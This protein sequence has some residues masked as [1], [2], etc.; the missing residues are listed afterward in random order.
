M[1]V[2]LDDERPM[3]EGFDVH[4]RT[5]SE[6][7]ETL[8]TGKV[9]YISLDHDLGPPEAGTGYDVAKWVEQMAFYG[10]LRRLEWDVH[11]ANPVGRK[12][13]SSSMENAERFWRQKEDSQQALAG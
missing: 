3:R 6:A 13:M 8:K 12:N 9:S 7:I 1:R 4:V 10:A 2:W 11:S 5:A